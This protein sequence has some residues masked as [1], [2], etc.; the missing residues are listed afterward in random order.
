MGQSQSTEPN[1]A[2]ST[3]QPSAQKTDY[4]ELLDVTRAATDD[5]IKKAYRRKALELHPDRN[6][7]NV[8]ETTRLFAEIQSAYEV[9]A[10]PQERA[11]YDSH[12]D[13]FLGSSGD[14]EEGQHSYNIR[15]TTSD[16]VLKFF[17]KFS[18]RMDFS[19][20]PTGFFGGLREQ[21]TQLA[22]E[23]RLACQW[24]GQEFAEYPSF[25]AQN[26]G[27]ESVV[28][29]FYASWSGFATKK[30]FAWKDTYRYAE[31]PDRRVRRLMEKEN[32]R[33]RE[34]GI[35]EFNEAV[36]SLVAF[37]K[38]RDPRYQANAQNEAQR[39][40]SLRQSVAAQAARSRAMNNAKLR[41]HI[42]P[43]W[44]QSREL[45]FSEDQESSES[46]VE[47]FECVVCNKSFKSQ[48][49]F[50]AH[51]RSKKHIKAVKQMCREMRM[52]NEDLDLEPT[53]SVDTP[54]YVIMEDSDHDNNTVTT[55]FGRQEEATISEKME[56]SDH[57]SY[58]DTE[59][60]T[61]ESGSDE[62]EDYASRESIEA[63][64]LSESDTAQGDLIAPLVEQLTTMGLSD[65]QPVPHVGK[66]KQ[67]RAKKAARDAEQTDGIVCTNC[68]ASFMS[69]TKLFAHIREKHAQPLKTTK[70]KR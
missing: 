53:T 56:D 25:G 57:G 38:K 29:P 10:D 22:L 36:R 54:D 21:F 24:E 9:L 66:A 46:E 27:F 6:Y 67:K 20:A 64:L 37:V 51:E 15:V 58:L 47:S 23:E 26:D 35:R 44:A 59:K 50:E 5:E 28:R 70:S 62:N 41:D 68:K 65:Q 45:D 2:N 42:V 52:E 49:Q 63:R 39:Q 8:E 43:D 16:E 4:Y 32:R 69:R 13:A 61:P 19:D 34:D 7:G 30:S 33:L 60:Q 17:S 55:S 12:S 48:K 18:P 40:E 1:A 14:P 11:W 3:E 31:A